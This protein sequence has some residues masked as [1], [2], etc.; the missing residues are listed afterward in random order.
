FDEK[1]ILSST[2]ALAIDKPVGSAVVVGAGYIGLEIGTYL[3][4]L[5]TNVTLLEQ[6]PRLLSYY[7]QDVANVVARN[8]K[9][10]NVTVLTQASAKGVKEKGGM[11]QVEVEVE[12]KTQQ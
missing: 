9:K 6:A 7:D 11:M 2:G 5:G 4:K 12:G 10:R 8:L 3:A 1:N